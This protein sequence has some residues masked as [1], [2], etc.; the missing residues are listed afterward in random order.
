MQERVC[1]KFCVKNGINGA[2]TMEMLEK[3]FGGDASKKTVVYRWHARFRDGRECIN[4]DE[5]TGRPSTSTNDDK[6][7]AIKKLLTKNCDL[8]V[9]E[10]AAETNISYGSVQG[11][12]S[13]QLGLRRVATKLVP[14]VLNFLQKKD[15]VDIAKD[16]LSEVD[17][18][19]TFIKR[20][21][22]G[23]ETWLFEYD[24]ETSRQAKKPRLLQSKKK[25]MLTAFIDYHGVVHHEFLPDGQTVTKEYYLGVM[26]RLREAVRNKRPDLWKDNSWILHHD[27]TPSHNAII[28]RAFLAK[29]NTNTIQQPS[30]SPDLAPCDFFLF[31]RLKKSLRVTRFNSRQEGMNKSLETMKSIP[32][33]EYKRCFEGWIQR[34]HMCVAEDGNYFEGDNINLDD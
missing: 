26:K 32:K 18:D 8:T 20:I 19:E 28:V 4:D 33:F 34:W 10:L 17:S 15:R 11:I 13:H 29:N 9:R 1:I 3:C 22:T 14:N 27:N 23:D 24:T 21:I 7:D 31:D 2:K 16:M 25:V 5:R 30:D 6:V 12:I